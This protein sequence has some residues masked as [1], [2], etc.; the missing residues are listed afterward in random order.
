MKNF[1]NLICL[2]IIISFASCEKDDS[3]KACTENCTTIRGR[4]AR[5]DN[6]GIQGVEVTF[7]Y[8]FYAP[9]S[10]K[11][12]IA[13]TKTDDNGNYEMQGY[14]N[15]NELGT[16]ETFEIA[17]DKAKVENSLS[18]AY[19]KPSELT[20]EVF[21]RLERVTIPG[22]ENRNEIIMAPNFI[23]PY[24][25][26]LTITLNNFVPAVPSDYFGFK[27]RVEY[28]FENQFILCKIEHA[29]GANA[30]FNFPAAVGNNKIQVITWK[31]NVNSYPVED[32][33]LTTIPSGQAF[34][35]DY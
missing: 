32:V 35:Y 17:I 3:D 19:L 25:T 10:Y 9:Y 2:A 33:L 30:T 31:N 28:G 11:R 1:L 20:Q 34:E 27:H 21:P 23:V 7:S 15:D 26:D 6:T 14:I 18:D 29:T 8:V 5:A 13:K 24:K 12:I 16:N 22:I 4:I